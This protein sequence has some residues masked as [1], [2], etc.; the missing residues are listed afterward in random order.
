MS[1]QGEPRSLRGLKSF[2]F[3]CLDY[4]YSVKYAEKDR[5]QDK[6]RFRAERT[7]EG[8]H[9]KA[10]QLSCR[11][12]GSYNQA[13]MGG[14]LK[15]NAPK[16]A[17]KNTSHGFSRFSSLALAPDSRTR[18]RTGTQ[19]RSEAGK[20]H[21]SVIPRGALALVMRGL[22]AARTRSFLERSFASGI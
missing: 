13:A 16:V 21:T 6:S 11:S 9:D 15:N 7:P 10:W 17:R 2:A 12:N 22:S 3:A 4:T 18:R 14:G 5:Q 1:Q 20:N 8:G 19:R